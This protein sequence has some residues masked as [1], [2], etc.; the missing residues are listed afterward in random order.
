VSNRPIRVIINGVPIHLPWSNWKRWDQLMQ[1]MLPPNP[2]VYEVAH[3]NARGSR[4]NRV[5]I[6]STRG[7]GKLFD[8]VIKLVNG[9][10]DGGKRI[11]VAIQAG[12]EQKSNLWIRWAET[13]AYANVE[14]CLFMR[15]IKIH[16]AGPRYCLE[17][18]VD[19]D[20]IYDFP[21]DLTDLESSDP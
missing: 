12:D 13:Q 1:N 5:Y 3:T 14:K 16:C 10:H 17:L 19:Y 2:G 11:R 4:A 7:G 6:G 15:Y 18:P 21:D 8:R 20:L 9:T